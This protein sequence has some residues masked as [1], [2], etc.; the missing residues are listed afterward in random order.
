MTVAET[1]NAAADYL[2]QHGWCQGQM[3]GP[4]DSVCAVGAI[5]EV[6]RADTD[7]DHYSEALEVAM[8]YVGGG[9]V[10]QWNDAPGRTKEDVIAMLRAAAEE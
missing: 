2:E 10:S 4:D 3:F 1:L 6:T 5:A 8:S 7:Y 9:P